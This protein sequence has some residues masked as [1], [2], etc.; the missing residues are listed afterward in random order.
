LSESD[1]KQSDW[2]SA[3]WQF[4]E[5]FAYCHPSRAGNGADWMGQFAYVQQKGE[6]K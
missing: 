3:G 2:T 6:M 1:T 5:Y 4:T